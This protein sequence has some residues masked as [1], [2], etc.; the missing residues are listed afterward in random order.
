M[1]S[2]SPRPIAKRIGRPPLAEQIAILP[3]TTVPSA[4][5]DAVRQRARDEGVSMAQ[6]VRTALSES[7][8]KE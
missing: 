4:V 1:D 6:V 3:P 7:L 2:S 5:Y 8:S